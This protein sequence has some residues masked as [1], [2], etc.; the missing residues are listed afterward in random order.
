MCDMRQ[1]IIVLTES[2]DII[3]NEWKTVNAYNPQTMATVQIKTPRADA[4]ANCENQ[5][6]LIFTIM[7]QKFLHN[8]F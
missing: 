4:P 5:S 8:I 7:I 2:S 1:Q 3:Q 6:H